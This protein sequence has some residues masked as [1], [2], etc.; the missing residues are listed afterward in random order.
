MYLE[1]DDPENEGKEKLK[2]YPWRMFIYSLL[3]LPRHLARF[4]D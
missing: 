3:P 4:G 1:K 2:V